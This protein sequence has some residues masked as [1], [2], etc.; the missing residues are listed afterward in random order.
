M[1]QSSA[2]TASIIFPAFRSLICGRENA[3]WRGADAD[4]SPADT[5]RCKLVATHELFTGFT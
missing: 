4:Y 2:Q 3:P 1:S 5:L